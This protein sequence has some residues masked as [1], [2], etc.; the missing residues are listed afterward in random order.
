VRL[1]D[2]ETSYAVLIGTANHTKDDSLPPL[3]GVGRNLVDLSARLTSQ[4]FGGFLAENTMRIADPDSTTVLGRQLMEVADRARDTLLVYYAGH[5]LVDRKGELFLSLSSTESPLLTISAL[6]V[7]FVIETI[8]ESPAR[9]RVLILDCCFSGRALDAMSGNASLI[10][11]QLQLPVDGYYFITSTPPNQPAIALEGARY[12]G[13][14]GSLIRLLSDGLPDGPE[15]LTLEQVYRHL[16][17]TLPDQGLPKPLRVGSNTAEL[18]ALTRNPAFPSPAELPLPETLPEHQIDPHYEDLEHAVASGELVWFKSAVFYEVLVQSFSD[19]NG[20]GIGD[21]RGLVERLDYCGWLGVDCLVLGP[22]F[23]SPLRDGGYDIRDFRAVRP[24]FGTVDDFASMLDEANRRGIRVIIDLALNHTSDAHPWFQESRNHP[25]GPYGD[26]YIWSDIDTDGSNWTFDRVRGQFFRHGVHSHEPDLNYANPEVAEAMLD[27]VRFWLDLGTAGFR[28][29]GARHHDFL[30]RCRKVV[31]DEYPGRVLLAEFDEW[32]SDVLD[33]FGDPAIGGDECHM[34]YHFPLTPMVFLAVG[35]ESRFPIVEILGR[36][37][38]IP[39]GTQWGIFLRNRD[40][41]ALE[42]VTDAERDYLYAEYAKDPRMRTDTGI[43][44]RLTTLLEGD[45]D[46]LKL[47]TALLLS[48]PGSPVLYYGDEVGMGDNIWLG[49]QDSVRTP[50]QWTADR[51]AGFSDCEPGRL[52]QPVIMDRVY[53]YQAVNVEAQTYNASSLLH[54]TRQMLQVRREHPAL[55][56]GDFIELSLFNP[57]VLGYLRRWNGPDGEQELILCVHNLSRFSQPVELVL[58][59]YA[60]HQPVELLGGVHFPWIGEL[61]YL[62]TL[63][64]HGFYWF[65]L[66]EP[67]D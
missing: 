52:H 65:Q 33:Y 60:G 41:L 29:P 51:N 44:R 66:T 34:A 21:L 8:K 47:L 31:D 32:Q 11:G 37:P 16:V 57:S 48:L 7:T 24:E 13:F 14:T 15:L 25:D 67:V 30:K 19:S 63:P 46:Q 55:R 42:K 36:T 53:G 38:E 27:V 9:N 58:G 28:L 64:G 3:P 10:A 17:V 45:H 6:A 20:D 54:R 43:R 4:E 26:Y 59:E 1:P 18:L 49:G 35:R 40:E 5:G 12:T 39:A 62:L 50:M 56:L 2:P 23:A 61:P 22:I